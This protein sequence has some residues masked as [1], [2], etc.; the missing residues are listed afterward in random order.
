M[1]NIIA[2]A[3]AAGVVLLA[4]LVLAG[5]PVDWSKAFERRT[6][7]FDW[8]RVTNRTSETPSGPVDWGEAFRKQGQVRSAAQTPAA[9]TP[10]APAEDRPAAP[11]APAGPPA[12]P[13]PA[14][15]PAPAPAPAPAPVPAVP[16][17]PPAAQ[18]APEPA[19]PAPRPDQ[20]AAEPL[21]ASP[22]QSPASPASKAGLA[23]DTGQFPDPAPALPEASA[24]ATVPVKSDPLAVSPVAGSVAPEPAAS[25]VPAPAA[26]VAPPAVSPPASPGP[27]AEVAPAAVAPDPAAPAPAPAPD[28]APAEIV[29]EP[30]RPAARKA[31][32]P[33]RVA[34]VE[35]PRREPL[36]PG[37]GYSEAQVAHFLAAAL[38]VADGQARSR[39]LSRWQGDIRLR[40]AGRNCAATE[41]LARS[42]AAEVAAA[43][44]GDGR[45]ALAEAEPANLLVYVLPSGPGEAPGYVQNAYD[46]AAIAGSTVV[47]YANRADRGA[48]LRLLLAALG[49]P[50][51][52]PSGADSVLCAGDRLTALDRSALELLYSPVVAPGMDPASARQAVGSLR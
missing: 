22:A 31:P 1:R 45:P 9:P 28:S 50:G 15:G 40:V 37:R 26:V 32:A 33:V 18:V 7:D 3:V 21:V 2:G 51:R 29:P 34:S 11:A 44:A 4:G 20:A 24:P 16:P 27:A 49:L 30:A 6:S 13:E 36:F 35:P 25:S 42:A 17:A 8:A 38:P 12:T 47:V 43:L 39:L 48:V 46:A 5:E 19:A 52:T 23:A 14:P 41:A 10:P